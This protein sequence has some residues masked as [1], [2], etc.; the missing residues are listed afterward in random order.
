MKQIP[1]NEMNSRAFR[2]RG[3]PP[4]KCQFK[5]L[6]PQ[7]IHL[8]GPN[9]F[10]SP[11][12]EILHVYR[13]KTHWDLLF[14]KGRRWS[15]AWPRLLLVCCF[16]TDVLRLPGIWC[17]QITVVRFCGQA[18]G[19]FF[20]PSFAEEKQMWN[21]KKHSSTRTA[22]PKHMSTFKLCEKQ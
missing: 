6:I 3:F 15:R 4:L 13:G 7:D 18:V 20:G 17:L 19:E 9:I 14:F 8:S 11:R 1:S 12:D 10:I 21:Y 5:I 22:F 16:R 2:L